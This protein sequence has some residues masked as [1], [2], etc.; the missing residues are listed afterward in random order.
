MAQREFLEQHLVHSRRTTT[1]QL[2]LSVCLGPAF[3]VWGRGLKRG[4]GHHHATGA[5]LGFTRRPACWV[6][7]SQ[8]SESCSVSFP[9][10]PHP[11]TTS[12]AGLVPAELTSSR[13]LVANA[14]F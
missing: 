6:R 4:H 12:T 7:T 11:T 2:P 9:H 14:S 1:H 8:D 13:V 10:C 5:E 3:W